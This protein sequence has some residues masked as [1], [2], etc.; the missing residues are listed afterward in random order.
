MSM[1]LSFPFLGDKNNLFIAN[2]RDGSA[3]LNVQ[4]LGNPPHVNSNQV[5]MV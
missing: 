4:A 2:E 5:I 3:V 1:I